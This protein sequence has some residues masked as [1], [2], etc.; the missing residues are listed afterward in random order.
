MSISNKIKTKFSFKTPIPSKNFS[1]L[2]FINFSQ[3]INNQL[4][5]LKMQT[6]IVSQLQL[7]ALKLGQIR[8]RYYFWEQRIITP[9]LQESFSMALENET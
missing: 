7:F 1:V 5:I 3:I 4:F 6:Y 9:R 8:V 2:D